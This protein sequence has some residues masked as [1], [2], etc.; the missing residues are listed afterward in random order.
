MAA[1]LAAILDFHENQYLRQFDI[2]HQRKI[3]EHASLGVI[4]ILKLQISS[5][6]FH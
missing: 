4:Y 3:I 2:P 1:I 6:L 5:S